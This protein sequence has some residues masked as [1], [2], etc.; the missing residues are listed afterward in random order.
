MT[1]IFD[2][3]WRKALFNLP[4]THFSADLKY[5]KIQFRVLSKFILQYFWF[6]EIFTMSLSNLKKNV[7]IAMCLARQNGVQHWRRVL[8]PTKVRYEYLNFTAK[9]YLITTFWFDE[10]FFQRCSK[11]SSGI[12]SSHFWRSK[13]WFQKCMP[14]QRF[15][16]QCRTRN[17]NNFSTHFQR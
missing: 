16:S 12:H 4:Q 8:G 10:F 3:I 2:K 6:D 13:K 7:F 11:K 17:W 1:K 15:A 9:I 5:P 14:W